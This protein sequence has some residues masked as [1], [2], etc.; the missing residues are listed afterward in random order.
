ML[1]PPAQDYEEKNY[2]SGFYPQIDK[3]TKLQL[4]HFP[5]K[6]PNDISSYQASYIVSSSPQ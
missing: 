1:P 4:S 6:L 3:K 5:A 2:A